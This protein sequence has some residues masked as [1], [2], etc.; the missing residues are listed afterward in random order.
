MTEERERELQA[1]LHRLD[2]K[3]LV[4]EL[5][6]EELQHKVEYLQERLEDAEASAIEDEED[7]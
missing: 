3:I 2:N 1:R 4:L 6:V 5:A 7:T